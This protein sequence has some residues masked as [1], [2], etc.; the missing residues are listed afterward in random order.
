MM[1]SALGTLMRQRG[2]RVA[3]AALSAASRCGGGGSG[4]PSSASLDSGLRIPRSMYSI[5][6]SIGAMRMSKQTGETSTVTS[7]TPAVALPC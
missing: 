3:A 7:S 5:P 4:A 6:R 1:R 2:R